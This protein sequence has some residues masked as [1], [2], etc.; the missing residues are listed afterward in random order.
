MNGHDATLP[1]D[2]IERR[3]FAIITAELGRDDFPDGTGTVV[4]RVIHATADFDFATTL[5]FSPGVTAIARAALRA[6]TAIVT[7]TAMAMAGINKN[8][9]ARLGGGVHCHI[10]DG[11]VAEAARL[12]GTTRSRAA[13]DKAVGLWGDAIYVIGNAPTALL[14]LCECIEEGV[15]RPALVIGVPVGFVNVCES[16]E[17]LLSAS[18]PSIVAR[19]RKGGSTVAAAICNALLYDALADRA[20]G[21]ADP[22]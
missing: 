2:E 14:R 3:S 11:E 12:A 5:H 6:G 18:V 10:A 17:R 1:P 15:V 9:V 7:D 19:G 21:P 4:K 13:V 16:K 22:C 8:A 20:D